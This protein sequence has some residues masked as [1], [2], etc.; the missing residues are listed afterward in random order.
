[1]FNKKQIRFIN[2]GVF[3]LNSRNLGKN[4][5][6]NDLLAFTYR[7]RIDQ[8]LLYTP[9]SLIIFVFLQNTHF[10]FNIACFLVLRL[11]TSVL[12]ICLIV[13]CH[14]FSVIE[15]FKFNLRRVRLIEQTVQIDA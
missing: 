15:I 6:Q 7:R 9:K 3:F 1:M 14:V 11:C 12:T 10:L 13:S 8:E 4:Y 2:P 5:T